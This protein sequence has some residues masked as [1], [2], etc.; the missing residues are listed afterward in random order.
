M[1]NRISKPPNK[2]PITIPLNFDEAMEA[3]IGVAP[4][5]LKKKQKKS[6]DSDNEKPKK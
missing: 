3:F 4:P 1:N 2:K 5:Q 6:D